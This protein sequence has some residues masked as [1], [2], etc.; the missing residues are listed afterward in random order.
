MDSTSEYNIDRNYTTTLERIK[1]GIPGLDSI[2]SGGIPK[3][4]ITLISGPPGSGKTILCLQFLYQGI[5]EGDRM[6]II[7]RLKQAKKKIDDFQNWKKERRENKR[8]SEIEAMTKE[9]EYLKTKREYMKLKQ[10]IKDLKRA[11]ASGI[12]NK[13]ASGYSKVAKSY[14]AERA[15]RMG[16][17]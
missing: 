12:L 6:D 15:R 3:N 17:K 7:R 1:T 14:H 2:I 9:L 10:E 5:E 11:T 16:T 4:T 13:L 8:T